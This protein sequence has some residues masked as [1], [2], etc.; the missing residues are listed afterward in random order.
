MKQIQ[1]RNLY[2]GAVI[3][4]D[5]C[6][7]IVTGLEVRSTGTVAVRLHGTGPTWQP[8]RTVLYRPHHRLTL[9]VVPAVAWRVHHQHRDRN[10][11]QGA[12]ATHTSSRLTPVYTVRQYW[13][14]GTDHQAVARL[15]EEHTVVTSI[16]ITLDQLPGE[17]QPTPQ[18]AEPGAR[19]FYRLYGRGP[20]VLRTGDDVRQRLAEITAIH[21][22]EH[23]ERDER[24]NRLA[25]TCP[26]RQCS[27]CVGGPHDLEPLEV[28]ITR[29]EHET[30]FADLP[31]DWDYELTPAM[32]HKRVV[33]AY[34]RELRPQQ[35]E[36]RQGAP[37]EDGD[38]TCPKCGAGGVERKC[39]QWA[40]CSAPACTWGGLEFELTGYGPCAPGWTT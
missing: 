15:M 23:G 16:P 14:N 31:Q 33:A 11:G 29:S 3:L 19:R 37:E 36:N 30:Q 6:P 28:V 21:D 10:T 32:A 2:E 35:P 17:G 8:G 4:T 40:V 1:A 26:V 38:L 20:T 39:R 12:G 7:T 22:R 24:D 27:R 25:P 13:A 5:F 18:P 34:G 9:C